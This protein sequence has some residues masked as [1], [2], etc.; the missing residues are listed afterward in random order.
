[1]RRERFL[2]QFSG[3]VTTEELMEYSRKGIGAVHAALLAILEE[4]V[5]DGGGGDA[6]G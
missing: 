1:M 4:E 6:R 5:A 2:D 3:R